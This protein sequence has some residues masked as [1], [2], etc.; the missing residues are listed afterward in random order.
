MSNGLASPLALSIL[1][2]PVLGAACGGNVVLDGTRGAGP[3]TSGA[4]GADAVGQGGALGSGEAR[5]ITSA[6]ARS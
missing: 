1:A 4:G 5:A 3:S 6:F 2:L